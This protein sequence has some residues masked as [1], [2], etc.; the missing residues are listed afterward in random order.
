[1]PNHRFD[2]E[3]FNLLLKAVNEHDGPERLVVRDEGVDGLDPGLR[4]IARKGRGVSFVVNYKFRD[5]HPWYRIG[6]FPEMSIETARRIAREVLAI[7]AA[8]MDPEADRRNLID[9]IDPN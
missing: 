3:T 7:A 8:G 6:D 5:A 9:R 1:M 4:A 2:A